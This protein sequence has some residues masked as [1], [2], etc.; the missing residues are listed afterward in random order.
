MKRAF[1]RAPFFSRLLG[2]AFSPL[3]NHV[4]FKLGYQSSETRSNTIGFSQERVILSARVN[5][6][7]HF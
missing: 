2:S 7:Y 5:F 6:G 4:F 3:L 1:F